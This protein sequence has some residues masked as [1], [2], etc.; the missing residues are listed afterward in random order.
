MVKTLGYD[1]VHSSSILDQSKSCYL[2][3]ALLASDQ[4]CDDLGIGCVL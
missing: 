3:S 1:P 4:V 2:L